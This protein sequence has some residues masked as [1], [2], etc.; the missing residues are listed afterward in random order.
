MS[1]VAINQ[2]KI[3]SYLISPNAPNRREFYCTAREQNRNATHHFM[4]YL[5]QFYSWLNGGD[6][7][8]FGT[9]VLTADRKL[10]V[11]PQATG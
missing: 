8:S 2:D 7:F 10:N 6:S 3:N 9:N 1:T 4:R 5:L 11:L